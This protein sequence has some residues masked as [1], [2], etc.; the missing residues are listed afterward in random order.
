MMN[1]YG[2]TMGGGGLGLAAILFWA[3]WIV[4]LVVGIFLAIYLWQKIT[5]K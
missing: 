4:Y 5:K 2:S 3:T 1:Y